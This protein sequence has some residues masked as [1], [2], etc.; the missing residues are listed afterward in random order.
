M[1]LL[2]A[3]LQKRNRMQ[4]RRTVST[5]AAHIWIQ[6]PGGFTPS[7]PF[8]LQ[9]Q[10]RSKVIVSSFLSR[11]LSTSSITPRPPNTHTHLHPL[12]FGDQDTLNPKWRLNG[13]TIAPLNRIEGGKKREREREGGKG[14]ERE[15]EGDRGG[16]RK[17]ET[18]FSCLSHCQIRDIYRVQS[19]CLGYCCAYLSFQ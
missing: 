5:L 2:L 9:M 6:A 19:N 8:W 17:K 18:C 1:L 10:H 15:K 14:W 4:G 7:S 3:V 12:L 16:E 11:T 13:H